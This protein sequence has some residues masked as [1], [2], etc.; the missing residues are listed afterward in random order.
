[1]SIWVK[2]YIAAVVVVSVVSVGILLYDIIQERKAL[3]KEEGTKEP[4]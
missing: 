4:R 2:I 3:R 1:M